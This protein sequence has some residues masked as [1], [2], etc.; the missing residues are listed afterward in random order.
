MSNWVNSVSGTMPESEYCEV[1]SLYIQAKAEIP[2]MEKVSL[3]N[4]QRHY[5]LGYNRASRLLEQ[6]CSAGI[7]QWNKATGAYRCAQ[8]KKGD[9]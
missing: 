5:N 1:E 7:L 9:A 3:L 4:V 2:L 6:L 8:G